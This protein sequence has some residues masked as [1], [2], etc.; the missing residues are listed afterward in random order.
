ME[1]CLIIGFFIDRA[2]NSTITRSRP[3]CDFQLHILAINRRHKKN[4]QQH[5]KKPNSYEPSSGVVLTCKCLSTNW[6][7]FESLTLRSIE[8][9]KDSCSSKLMN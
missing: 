1:T 8:S 4:S 7:A 9:N 6:V 2:S 3:L 5:G